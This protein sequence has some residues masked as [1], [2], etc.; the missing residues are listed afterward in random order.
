M[1]PFKGIYAVLPTPLTN[2]E[3]PDL[4]AIE[5]L[6][7]LLIENNLALFALGSSGEGMN[8][9]Y[10][11]RIS[12]ARKIAEVN[13]GRVPLLMGGGGFSVRESLEF[14]ESIKDCKIDGVHLIPY[15]GKISG[16]AI[17]LFFKEVADNSPLPIWLYQNNTRNSGI[18]IDVASYLSH[19]HNIHGM[20]LAGFDLRLNQKF[21]SL[22]NKNFQVFGSA[23]IQMYTFFCLGLNASSSSSAACFPELFADLYQTFKTNNLS[24]IREK[25]SQIMKF[26]SRMPKGAYADNGESASEVKYQLYLRGI[27][28]EY[29]AKPF[30][31]QNETEKKIS[32]K[33]HQDYLHYLSTGEILLK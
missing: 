16:Q 18:P 13:N 31:T 3:N 7:N 5:K 28:N 15:D 27:C 10:S 9:T 21:I 4:V 12:A 23:D 1:H 29:V 32:D 20:K 2:E 22:N 19:H 14:I 6:V 11:N 8:L 17:K 33:V 24:L 25:N 30:R 26:I